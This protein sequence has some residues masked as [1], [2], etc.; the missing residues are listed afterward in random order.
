MPATM[1]SDRDEKSSPTFYGLERSCHQINSQNS[2]A[3]ESNFVGFLEDSQETQ[4]ALPSL[5]AGDD[6]HEIDMLNQP[7]EPTNAP[8]ISRPVHEDPTSFEDIDF[9]FGKAPTL[10]ILPFKPNVSRNSAS[11][12]NDLNTD[13]AS[14]I[15]NPSYD[16]TCRPVDDYS[17]G[18]EG[19]G[20]IDR[21]DH[22]AVLGARTKAYSGAPISSDPLIPPIT[23]RNEQSQK[24]GRERSKGDQLPGLLF[25]NTSPSN[26]SFQHGKAYTRSLAT[27][28]GKYKLPKTFSDIQRKALIQ[29]NHANRLNQPTHRSK[30]QVEELSPS[31][32]NKIE[33][34]RDLAD[35]EVFEHT[36]MRQHQ[37]Q[38]AGDS[39]LNEPPHTPETQ[40]SDTAGRSRRYPSNADKIGRPLTENTSKDYKIRNRPVSQ[41][42]NISKPR[43]ARTQGHMRIP[44]KGSTPTLEETHALRHQLGRA[45]NNF[46]VNED[47]RNGHWERKLGCLKEQL[48]ERDDKAAEYLA[49]IHQQDRAIADLKVV[50][51]EQRALY[52]KQRGSLEETERR[53]QRLKA[54]AKEYKDHL[55]D[56]IKEQQ[57]M[58][59]YFQPRYHEMKEQ[60][61]QAE[62][63][64]QS[65]LEEALATTNAIRDK[66]QGSV[67]EAQAISQREVEKLNQE[68]SILQIRLEEREK[69]V[70]REKDHANY[71][72]QQLEV[73]HK[74]FI[75]QSN[76]RAAQIQNI[77]KSIN[78]QEKG[79][80]SLLEILENNNQLTPSYS[81]LIENMK[82]HQKELLDSALL[83]FQER[84]TS[85]RK[86]SSEAT[87]DLK[88]DIVAVRELCAKISEQIR[89]GQDASVWQEKFT[90][91]QMDHEAMSREANELKAELSRMQDN[92]KI[93]L[94]KH[95]RLEQELVTLRTGAEAAEKLRN[96]VQN[97]EMMKQK[98]EEYLSEKQKCIQGLE[99]QLKEAEEKLSNQNRQL[100]DKERQLHSQREEHTLVV[101][102]HYEQQERAVEQARAEESAKAQAEYV[103]I[104]K[105]L[106]DAMQDC[107]RLQKE[108]IQVKQEAQDAM[109]THDDEATR[110]M[111]EVV[112]RMNEILE[113][114]EAFGQAKHDLTSR[115]EEWSND[116]IELS[117]LQQTVEKLSKSHQEVIDD[118]KLLEELLDIQRKLDD[119]WRFHK[120]EAD[121]LQ[122][123]L[124]LERS[125]KADR[126]RIN[127]SPIANRRVMIHS[128]ATD[129][130]GGED[131]IP[132]SIEE[133]R[134]ARRQVT[135]ITGIIKLSNPQGEGRSV[136]QHHQGALVTPKQTK[137]PRRASRG[138]AEPAPVSYSAYNRPVLGAS[139]RVGEFTSDR[140]PAGDETMFIGTPSIPKKRRRTKKATQRDDAREKRQSTGKPARIIRSMSNYF[141]NPAPEE[142][143]S[144]PQAQPRQLRGGPIEQ[145]SRP[146]TTYGASASSR[147]KHTSAEL[148]S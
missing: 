99:D 107:S 42:S 25:Q 60:L 128:P 106:Q 79:M 122:R 148:I 130:T 112:N 41:A 132:V 28:P 121:A 135:S 140:I 43:A 98:T 38:S 52:E 84:A 87:Q 3:I 91:A 47:R 69:D 9:Q 73:S 139:A 40:T 133:E 144:Q 32:F 101:A 70:D 92:A 89:N 17:H 78:N 61:K 64:Y 59:K 123:A 127:S 119:T 80:Q 29:S 34:H 103:D 19:T 83:C 141:H 46:F 45:W 50:N 143:P 44:R 10:K 23:S 93:R 125:V 94:K 71:L 5:H 77:E 86:I 147:E 48:A 96:R 66:I 63:N 97:L 113:G 18:R 13:G 81:E 105:R 126:E 31:K 102:S 146:F 95:E 100:T 145:R 21:P 116:H 134:V 65:S 22:T 12:Q 88:T 16:S 11:L 6:D 137:E 131:I 120:S 72:R 129:T 30:S 8:L 55:N 36:Q 58:F 26:T 138:N 85:D 56:A 136:E 74:E 68:I 7:L 4:G 110:Q 67:Q 14:R 49:K 124:D 24:Q 37:G 104:E 27:Q 109:R 1:G 118:R 39:A 57:N 142:P 111:E 15:I 51:E 20:T 117:L 114:L 33:S 76:G 62:L 90:K 2:A 35:A 53:V 115:L 75:R 108:L 54:R 82:A